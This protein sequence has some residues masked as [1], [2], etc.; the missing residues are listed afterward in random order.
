M[1]QK[2]KWLPV[3]ADETDFIFE[4]IFFANISVDIEELS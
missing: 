3:N 4:F 1:K 2:N